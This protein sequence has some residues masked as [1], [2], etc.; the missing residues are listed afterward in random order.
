MRRNIIK[1]KNPHLRNPY[2]IVGWPGMGEVAFRVTAYLIDKLK[3][4]EFAE[5]NPRA[6][7]HHTSCVVN[8]GIIRITDLPINKFFFWKNP[9]DKNDLVIFLSSAQPDFSKTKDYSKLILDVAREYKVKR[10]YGF[11]SIPKTVDH[12]KTPEVQAACTHTEDMRKLKDLGIQIMDQGQISGMNGIFIALAK[13]KGFRGICLLGEI[14]VYAIHIENP[15]A[16][17]EI[18]KI[19]TRLID[20]KIDLSDLQE[21]ADLVEREISKLIDY[22]KGTSEGLEP[23]GEEE[24]EKIKKLLSQHSF[25]PSSVSAKIEKLFEMARKD[26]SKVGELKKELDRWSVYKDYEDRFL[27]LFKKKSKGKEN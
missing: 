11:A 26:L 5:I 17:L 3:A 27:D 20:I 12:V 13:S 19:F 24:I 16:A 25:L 7:F 1:L 8:K 15:K 14:P 4:E 9:E 23:I 6:F 21:Q 2:L 10:I 18:L 22:V